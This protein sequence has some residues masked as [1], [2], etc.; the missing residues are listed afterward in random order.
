MAKT[1]LFVISLVMKWPKV[2]L[3]SILLLASFLRLWKLTVNPVSL[4]GDELDLGYQAYS[5]LQTGRDYNGNFMPLHFHSMAEW[6]T[7]LYLYSAVPTVAVFGITPLG[8]RLPAA[9]FGILGVLAL[10]LLVNEILK[11]KG[12]ALLSAGMLAVSPWHLQYSRAGFEVSEMLF[13]LLIGL[14]LF[15][16]TLSGKNGRYLWMSVFCLV[17]TPWI[18]STAKL[19]TPLLLVFLFAV[20]R[21]EILSLKRRNLYK[22]ALAGLVVGLPIVY[23][24][25]FGGGT[26]RFN[27]ISVF[28][29][30]TTIPEVGFLRSVDAG[31][32]GET[33][34]GL[35]PKLSDR[36]LHN[37]FIQWGGVVTRNVFQAFS[38]EFLFIKGDPNPRQ[39]V[40]IG[41]FYKI[42]ALFLILGVMLFFT[43]FP[44]KRIK[45]LT[46]FWALAGVIPAAITRDGGNHA[47]RLILVLPLLTVLIAYGLFETIRSFPRNLRLPAAAFYAFALLIGF[48]FYQHKYLVHYPYD[49]E[50]WWHYG[51]E[52]AV[53]EIKSIDAG[54]D[55]VI[56]SMSGE[57]AWVFFAGAYRFPPGV[58][59][60][61]FSPDKGVEV[62]GFGKISHVGKFYF[63][64]PEP[65]IQ[66]YG[67]NRVIDSKTLYLAN[68]KEVGANLIMEPGKAPEGLN[69]IKIVAFPSG[70]PAFYLFSG[71][72]K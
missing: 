10:Y 27:Y 65:D 37:K 67:L 68:A 26:D 41:E 51:W 53:S 61:E 25:L 50:R 20:W 1:R 69:L 39:S 49:S 21:K 14:W 36:I 19:F 48:V 22:A 4:F 63:G 2:F 45:L 32:R 13:F 29:D 40:G 23:A 34:I 9:F 59:Q 66:I 62:P 71:T 44:D 72:A 12:L 42:D 33:G 54:Y 24:T 46:A 7:P 8:V 64:S 5:I 43:K 30:P 6:R 70:E 16:K 28:S 60:K 57:P 17:L 58:W 55:R 11:D 3:V 47:T 35:S 31:V 38:T 18:Y 56:I 52:D 15:F